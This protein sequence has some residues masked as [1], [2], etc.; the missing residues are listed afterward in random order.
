MSVLQQNPTVL[1]YRHLTLAYVF[2]N[3]ELFFW[4]SAMLSNHYAKKEQYIWLFFGQ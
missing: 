3:E 4:R 1:T 2:F